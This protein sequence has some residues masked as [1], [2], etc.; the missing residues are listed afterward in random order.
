[1]AKLKITNTD[2][3][4]QIHDKSVS[5]T[6]VN[7]FNVGGT[8]G[9]TSQ[10]GSQIQPQVKIGSAGATTGS[11]L[12]QKGR[13]EFRVYDGSTVG[14]CTLVNLATP[15][16]ADTMSI[17]I[18]TAALTTARANAMVAS[19]ASTTAYITNFTYAGPGAL[20]VG[21]VVTGTGA[22]G[23]VTIN[24]VSSSS[25]ITVTYASQTFAN[26]ASSTFYTTLNASRITNRF[27][28]DFGTATTNPVKYRYH[29]A[30]PDSTFVKVRSA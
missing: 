18:D 20:A 8:G 9:N 15:T 16:A 13:K 25:N 2:S 6:L 30:E 17:Q 3:S 27:V 26:V 10:T 7:G 22:T 28:H 19:G 5:P 24:A 12:A 21:Q 11:I 29:L 1:M 23:T 14:S 4:G